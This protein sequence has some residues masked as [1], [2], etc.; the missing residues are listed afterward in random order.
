MKVT[1]IAAGLFFL[2]A[3][4]IPAQTPMAPAPATA[5]PAPAP[6]DQAASKPVAKPIDAAKLQDIQ[7]LLEV[8]NTKA[9]M[10]EVM[11]KVMGNMKPMLAQSLPPGAYRDKLVDAFFVRFQSERDTDAFIKENVIPIYDHY[12]ED[13]DIKGLIEFYQTP[14]GKKFSQVQPDMSAELMKVGQTWGE[15]LGRKTMLGVLADNPDLEKQLEEAGR[16]QAAAAQA[17][18]H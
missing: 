4:Q 5:Q 6:A 18:Q 15:D 8:T 13:A 10:N 16:K 17:A 11:D 9:R 12:F 14:L 3:T 7:R 1:L 2:G